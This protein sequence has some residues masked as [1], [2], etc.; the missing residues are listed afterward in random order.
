M[1]TTVLPSVCPLDCPDTCSLE[2]TV[3]DGRLTKVRGS[4]SNPFSNGTICAKVARYPDLVYSDDRIASPMLRTGRRGGEFESVNWERALSV[5]HERF[6]DVVNEHGPQAIVPFNYAGPHG[7]LAGSSMDARFFNRLG[8]S[9]LWRTPLCGGIKSEA[10]AGTFGRVPCMRPDDVHHARLIIV[11]GLNVTASQLHLMDEIRKA[12][13]SGA[14]LVIIDPRRIPVARHADMHLSIY[15]GTDVLLGFALAAELE[16][17]GGFDQAFIDAHVDGADAYMAQ[18]REVTVERAAVEC[19]LDADN[20]RKLARWYKDTSPAVVCP[21]NGAE[22]NRNGGSNL[23]AAFALPA[24][25]GKFGVLGGGVLQ[26]AGASFP[27]TPAR[28]ERPELMPE[29]TRT[30]NILDMGR[31]L[32]DVSMSPPIKALFTYNHNPLVV[33]PEQNL[34]RRGLMR[35]DLFH[36]VCDVVMTDTAKLADVVLPACTH[37]EH[38]ELFKAY[39]THYLQRARPV[40]E[41]LG[42][43]LPNT[44]IFRRLATVFGFRDPAFKATDAEL[45]DDA[46]DLEDPR[47]GGVRPSELPLDKATLMTFD[48]ENAQLFKSTEPQTPSGKIELVS[49]YLSEKYDAP[50]PKFTP[51]PGKFPLLLITPGSEHRTSS[52]FGGLR[53]STDVS[54][55]MHPEDAFARA[56]SDGQQVR[57][58]NDLGEVFARLRITDEVTAGVASSLKGLWMRTAA[59]GQTVS[60]LAP[61]TKADICE[62]A[63]YNDAEVEIEAA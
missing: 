35:E 50:L 23:R 26:G 60:A 53:W 41:P 33:H 32:N 16:R 2:T 22:R 34:M 38:N 45:M 13:K 15:P 37:F 18:A 4:N 59:N 55:D 43:A 20:I 42:D 31:H 51:L 24:L 61:A 57:I 54:V 30:L 19:R 39:G 25:C 7:V 48:G 3:E 44:E 63:C 56:L 62:G 17:I 5:I 36:V 46:L 27:S 58:Y 14:R 47:L 28:L 1:T 21:G 52:T 10:F 49:T 11:W 29:G 40:I 6:S 9:Q 8:A 12:R